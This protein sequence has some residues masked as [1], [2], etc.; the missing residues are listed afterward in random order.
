MKIFISHSSNDAAYG[1]ALVNLLTGVGVDHESIV[2]TSDAAYG[3]P[4]GKNIFDWLKEQIADRPFV[5][6]LLSSDYYSSIAC[7]NEMGAAWIVEN[8]HTAIFTPI[9]QLDDA[10][11][12]NGALDPRE[13][14]FYIN[15]EDRVTEFIDSLRSNFT[16]TDKQAVI[17]RKRREFLDSIGSISPKDSVAGEARGAEVVSPHKQEQSGKAALEGL[18]VPDP[19]SSVSEFEH[20]FIFGLLCRDEE[21]STKVSETYLATLAPEDLDAIGEWDSFCELNKL[22]WTEHGD[23]SRLST[24]GDEYG[25]NSSVHE[26]VARGYLH[27]DDFEKA[28]S[29]F[30][31][32]IKYTEDR[33]KKLGLLGDLAEISQELVST[34]EVSEILQEMRDLVKGPEDEELLLAKLTNLSDWYKDDVL[35]AAMLERELAIDPTDTSKRFD[36]AYLYSQTGKEALSMFHYEKIPA[37]Q[38][39]GM[40]WNNLGVAYRHFSIKGKSINAFRK[41]EEK[42]ET[43]A[44]SNLAYEL[45]G[46]GFLPEAE[47]ILRKAQSNSIYHDNVA[48]ALVRLKEIPGK[49]RAA[50]EDKLKGVTS[51]SQ[52]LSHVGEHLWLQAPNITSDTMSDSDCE[53][54][55]RIEG[56]LFF[57]SGSFQR[58]APPLGN[59]LSGTIIR[60]KDETYTVEYRGRFIGKVVIGERTKKKEGSGPTVSTLLGISETT[61]KFIIVMPEGDKE[62]RGMVGNDLSVFSLASKEI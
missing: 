49:E 44:M 40:T 56:D 14:G 5:I 48:S 9:F 58:K 60:E 16:I 21:H 12:R 6:F 18:Q 47:E 36:L 11:F 54:I 28:K 46:S 32:A 4:V 7:L 25:E 27:F 19:S 62:V 15:D 10:R 17:S 57:A 23:L 45:M 34:E 20:Q 51:K 8:Q 29:H 31:I 2:F 59:S 50:H 42:G 30:R 39:N 37:N 55:I 24:L 41:A 52:F 35:K 33:S 43:L 1:R 53:L 22:K 3:I 13:I 61:Q 38:R 26:H